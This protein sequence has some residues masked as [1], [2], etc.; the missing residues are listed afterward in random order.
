MRK[1]IEMSEKVGKVKEKIGFIKYISRLIPHVI[2]SL[3]FR[4]RWHNRENMPEKGAGL[5]FANH[6]GQLDMFFIATGIK[7]WIYWI[8]KEEL[9][10]NPLL[11]AW[12]RGVGAF[13]VKRSTSDIRSA[14]TVF[15]LLKE[16]KVVGIFPEGTRQKR[17]KG[18]LKSVKS[19]VALFALKA[20]VPLIPVAIKG[21]YK[22]FGR[23]DIY[24]GKPYRLDEHRG[25]KY[26][27]KEL[28]EISRNIM[29]NIYSL[30]EEK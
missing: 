6:I 27:R 14:R 13:P 7:R 17:W 15:K 29:M 1:G 26:T 22:L 9:F 25:K 18:D 23:I 21:D 19:G 10:K 3:I 30:A 2:L 16:G 4:I 12:L 20:D 5:L 11:G 24:C 28:T 8:S